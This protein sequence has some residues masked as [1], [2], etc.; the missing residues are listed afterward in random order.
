MSYE[1]IIGRYVF[2][3]SSHGLHF[4]R[5]A[6]MGGYG[7]VLTDAVH[8]EFTSSVTRDVSAEEIASSDM[9]GY[10]A[11]GI[12]DSMLEHLYVTDV[13]ELAIVHGSVLGFYV[14]RF[15]GISSLSFTMPSGGVISFVK[16]G[17][18][19][20]AGGLKYNINGYDIADDSSWTTWTE[21]SYEEEHVVDNQP[22]TVTVY[23]RVYNLNPGDTFFV[24][25]NIDTYS[26]FNQNLSDYFNFAFDGNVYSSGDVRSVTA[27]NTSGVGLRDY[28]YCNLF[29]NCSTLLSAPK[30]INSNTAG[31]YIYCYYRMFKGCSKLVYAPSISLNGPI[32]AHVCEEMFYG[33]SSLRYV[34]I[35]SVTSVSATDCIA[36]WVY[37]VPSYGKFYCKD[38]LNIPEYSVSGIPDG[39]VRVNA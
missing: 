22:V 37:G 23:K 39:W 29:L 36:N 4:G 6:E 35:R 15:Y 21:N 2:I 27:K 32:K 34:Y 26:T 19:S 8:I 5:L 7:V 12:S 13:S 17:N 18:P 9:S 10:L 11:S 28:I 25:R 33:C 1:A 16:N 14:N 3:K 38:T 24:R 31:D 30:L 20:L